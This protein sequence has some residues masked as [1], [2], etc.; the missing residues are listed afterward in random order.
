MSHSDTVPRIEWRRALSQTARS[1][2]RRLCQFVPIWAWRR[3]F[4][5][6]VVF[7][8]YH[9]VSDT[10]V[11]HLKHYPFL[12]TAEFERDL[13]TL[14][15]RFPYVSYEQALERRSRADGRS[16]TS[17]CIT[18]DDGFA[19]CAS[20]VRPI[21]LRHR[22]TCIFF[23][24][25]DLIDNRTIFFETLSSLCIEAILRHPPATVEEIVRD[26]DLQ[27]HLP[28]A[29]DAQYATLPAEMV[30][31]W[32]Q[33]EPRLRPLLIW[34]LT[35]PP[36]DAALLDKLCERL[37]VDAAGYVGKV[38]PFLSAEQIRQLRADGFTI[39]AHSMS[40]RRLQNLPRAEAE[41][42]IVESCRI[43]H[44]LTGQSSV[45]FAFPYFGDG[46]DR[47]WLAQLREQ[48]P[49]IGLF[50]DTR[51]LRQDSPAVAQRVFGERIEETGSIDRLL[52][53]AWL[54]RLG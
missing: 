22:A 49:F 41:R 26:L 1:W 15:A 45:P 32:E 43:I 14:E 25:T 48:H 39:G 16:D 21:L 24:I 31:H 54:R 47:A 29:G 46:L 18:F 17:V 4:P 51:G 12:G 27:R 30:K 6:P 13:T 10:R 37:Q 7:M 34:L 53:R 2:S 23:I 33:F 9:M 40:H 19:E 8:C 42:E 11:A 52:R 44:E 36:E 28:A 3:V 35:I 20:V 5:E 50:F 38:R